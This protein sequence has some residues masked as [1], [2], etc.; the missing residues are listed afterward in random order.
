MIPNPWRLLHILLLCMLN[1]RVSRGN[2]IL[3]NVEADLELSD[4]DVKALEGGSRLN[5]IDH[6]MESQ[7]ESSVGRFVQYQPRHV[8]I[9]YGSKLFRMNNTLHSLFPSRFIENVPL[10]I[11]NF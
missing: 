5:H 6:E 7:V 9:S 1:S 11:H 3:I 2:Y 8:H 10:S 4:N